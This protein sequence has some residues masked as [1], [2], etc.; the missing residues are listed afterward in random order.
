M[1][2]KQTAQQYLQRVLAAETRD[3]CPMRRTRM[4]RPV[5]LRPGEWR[6]AVSARFAPAF[7]PRGQAQ[8]GHTNSAG[9]PAAGGA[10]L[11]RQAALAQGS[12]L[13]GRAAMPDYKEL[14]LALFR[15]NEQAIRTLE[16]A[17]R[18]AEQA[19]LAAPEPPLTLAPQAEKTPRSP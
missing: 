5:F 6:R 16:Q 10:R 2:Q 3:D 18:A 1:D 11:P 19:V 15:A 12:T 17:Q 4:L 7:P 13:H 9:V 14:Y 8:I